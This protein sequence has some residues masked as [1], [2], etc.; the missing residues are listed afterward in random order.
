MNSFGIGTYFN[1]QIPYLVNTKGKVDAGRALGDGLFIMAVLALIAV[2]AGM[3]LSGL[4]STYVFHSSSGSYV[5]ILYIAMASVFFS[6]LYTAS[7]AAVVSF[8]DGKGAAIASVVYMTAQGVVSV[9]LVIL[10]YG[11]AG[12]IW[13]MLVGFLVGSLICLAY[14]QT[15][16]RIRFQP[17]GIGGRIGKIMRFSL[18]LSGAN[19]IGSMPQSLALV[20]LGVFT[21][22]SVAGDYGV[23]YRLISVVNS[24]IGAALLIVLPTFSAVLSRKRKRKEIS[25][26]YNYALFMG[27][28]FV[29]PVITYMTVF[30][31]SIVLAVFPGYGNA[32]LYIAM[33]SLGIFLQLVG[34]FANYLIISMGR[35][36]KVLI[37][38]TIV[39]VSEVILLFALMP[40]SGAIGAI[41]VLY[42]FGMIL[43]AYLY[44][45]A[46]AQEG[47]H[48]QVHRLSMLFAANLVL[49]VLMAMLFLVN[50]TATVRLVLGMAVLIVLYPPIL[51]LSGVVDKADIRIIGSITRKVP[52]MGRLLDLMLAYAAMFVR[53]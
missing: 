39:G 21:T 51:V 23:A 37:Y 41:A 14:V 16:C 25:E 9:G 33:M 19:F 49:A 15:Q 26:V 22:I 3:L 7:Q 53:N 11:A 32:Y 24:V 12:A 8:G 2:A 13:G 34:A 6:M 20:L 29:A 40:S 46:A 45:N 31:H 10:G 36:K 28:L 44:M 30:S 27:V 17:E 48:T 50:T 35:V 38:S 43:S 4:I 52:A 47:V 5:Y 18:P 42:F 1:K